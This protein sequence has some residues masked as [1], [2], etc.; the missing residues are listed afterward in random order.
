MKNAPFY[1]LVGVVAIVLGSILLAVFLQATQ[2]QLPENAVGGICVITFL[3]LATIGYEIFTKPGLYSRRKPM[4]E[5]EKE[6][7]K[8]PAEEGGQKKPDSPRP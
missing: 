6:E 7:E 4:E 3:I 2:G 1:A 8:E 5:P